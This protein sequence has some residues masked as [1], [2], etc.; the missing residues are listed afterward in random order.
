MNA[1]LPQQGAGQGGAGA[2]VAAPA[3]PPVPSMFTAARNNYQDFTV[4]YPALIGSVYRRERDLGALFPRWGL[5]AY[6]AVY[7]MLFAWRGWSVGSWA[8]AVNGAIVC[9]PAFLLVLAVFFIHSYDCDR[10]ALAGVS[11]HQPSDQVDLRPESLRI[12]ADNRRREP[13]YVDVH[14]DR[15]TLFAIPYPYSSGRFCIHRSGWHESV[16]PVSLELFSQVQLSVGPNL[17][18]D[19]VRV[20]AANIASRC[21]YVKLDR[22]DGLFHINSV[23]FT[24]RFIEVVD[25]HNRTAAW[26][27]RD[28]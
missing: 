27:N 5:V 23:Q 11:A 14:Y 24:T 3:P 19:E 17:T 25:W 22:Y 20:V 12:C 9:L 2:A 15:H 7:V 28:F 6:C 13:L 26:G 1:A 10:F 21:P 16:A 8:V 4:Q 18:A